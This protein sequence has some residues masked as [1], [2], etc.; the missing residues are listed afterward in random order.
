MKVLDQTV[1]ETPAAFGRVLY[2]SLV[3]CLPFVVA[4]LLTL[5]IFISGAVQR[6][7][8]IGYQTQHAYFN[9]P[10]AGV[11]VSD[12]FEVSGR[13]ESIPNGE[14]V[15]L[16]ERVNN[17]FWPKLRIGS[18]PTT[19]R[20]KQKTSSGKGYKYTIELLS[21]DVAAQTQIKQWFEQGKKTGRYP[22]ISTID[23]V[24]VLAKVRVVHK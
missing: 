2:V 16:V 19:F 22:G 8:G 13:I 6:D 15:Y 7:D 1:F 20:R 9:F 3:A 14:V 12:E 11:L 10:V 24:S 17:M 18:E 5:I 21:A 4:G 23:G